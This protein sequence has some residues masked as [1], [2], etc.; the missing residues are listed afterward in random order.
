MH[1]HIGIL[2][3][4]PQHLLPKLQ[5]APR[6][7]K[8]LLDVDIAIRVVHAHPRLARREARVRRAVPLHGR[9]RIIPTHVANAL[10]RFLHGRPLLGVFV[11][12]LRAHHVDVVDGLDVLVVLGAPARRRVDGADFL[13]LVEEQRARER[14]EQDGQQLSA[15]G[16]VLRRVVGVAANAARLVVVLEEDGAPGVGA[17]GQVLE[18]VEDALEIRERVVARAELKIGALAQVDDVELEDHVELLAGGGDVADDVLGL[19]RVRELAHRRAVVLAQDLFVHFAQIVMHL[20]PVA[21]EGRVELVGR[22][23]VAD[24]SVGERHGFA[25]HVD[26]VHAEAVDAAVEP[27]LHGAVEDGLPGRQRLPVQVWLLGAEQMK[28]VFLRPFVPGPSGTAKVGTPVVGGLALAMR[29]ALS[30]PPNIPIPFW[31]GL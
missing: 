10:Q 16:P 22:G 9:A 17:G 26:R 11:R 25:V 13:T 18:A 6:V 3:P 14:G 29:I 23:V 21:E 19:G 27:K 28:V 31:G 2:L 1:P 7:R 20:G 5:H 15:L 8:L 12:V 4:Q 30:R 24:Q